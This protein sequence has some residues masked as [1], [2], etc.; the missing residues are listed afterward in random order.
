MPDL[1]DTH[2]LCSQNHVAIFW[3]F[4]T[5]NFLAFQGLRMVSNN[6]AFIYH[7]FTYLILAVMIQ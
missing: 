3:P 7:L 1:G 6:I 2:L 5:D 4:Q